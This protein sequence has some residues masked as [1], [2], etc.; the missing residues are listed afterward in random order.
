MNRT[1]T[2][3]LLAFFVA[4]SGCAGASSNDDLL[5]VSFDPPAGAS[6]DTARVQPLIGTLAEADIGPATTPGSTT[7]SNGTFTVTSSGADIW[8]PSDAFHFVYQTMVGDGEAIARVASQPNTNAWAKAGFMIRESV[9]VGAPYAFMALTPGNGALSQYRPI[10]NGGSQQTSKAGVAAPYWVRLVRAGSTFAGYTS[11]DGLA[12]TL[13]ATVTVPM[14]TN[15][16]AGLAVTSHSGGATATVTFTNV[17]VAAIGTTPIANVPPT[18]TLT[19]PAAGT[20]Y[21]APASLNLAAS[22]GDSDGTVAKVDFFQG[23]TLVGTATTGPFQAAMTGLA[24][25]T[26]FLTARATD[27]DGASTTSAPVSVTVNAAPVVTTSWKDQDIGSTG[28]AGSFV[29]AGGILTVSGAGADVWGTADAFHFAYLPLVGDGEVIARVA[30]QQNTNAWAKAGVMIRESTAAGARHAFMAMTPSYG[31]SFQR[32]ATA[33]GSS[34]STTVAGIKVP[35]WVRL[36]RAGSTFTAYTSADG[37]TWRQIGSATNAMPANAL[38]GLAVTSHKA[39]TLS[40]ATFTGMVVKSATVTPPPPAN[41]PPTVG[42]TSPASGASFTA[43]ATL[44]VSAGAADSD[45]S[46]AKVEFFQGATLIGTSTASPFQASLS[47][48]AA[49]SYALTAKATDNAGASTTSA[50]VSIA[51]AAAPVANV[52]PTVSI[53]SPANG[54]SLTAPA[55]LTVIAGA[56]DSDGAVA[57]VDFFQGSALVGTSTVTPFQVALSNLAAGT[58]ALT[59][60]ATDNAGA[61]TTSA[62]VSITVAGAPV[63]PPPGTTTTILKPEVFNATSTSLKIRWTAPAGATAVRVFLAPEPPATAGAAMPAQ[64]Q[65]ASLAG[66]AT[67]AQLT[68]LAAAVDVFLRIDVDTPSGTVSEVQHG[69]TLGGPREPLDNAVREVHG[70]GPN[71]LQIV[72]FNGNGATFQAGPWTVTRSNGAAINVTKVSRQSLPISAPSYKVGYGLDYSDSIIDADHRIYL[73]LDAPIGGPDLLTVKGPGVSFL[74]PFSDNYLETPI[75]QLNQVGY[76]PRAT[77]RYA[78]VSGWMGDGGALSLSGLSTTADVLAEPVDDSQPRTAVKS[79][80]PIT[81]RSTLDADTQAEVRQIDLGGVAAAEGVRLR[82]RIPGVGV[83][84]PT[85]ISATAAYKALFTVERGLFFNRWGADIEAVSMEFPR[86]NLDHPFVYTAESTMDFDTKFPTTQPLT[87]KRSLVG[88]YHDAGDFDQRPMHQVIPQVLMRA[89]EVNPANYLDRQFDIPEAGNGIPDLLDEAMWGVNAWVQLQE[90]A[91]GVRMGVESTRHP[92]AFY[93]ADDDPLIYWTYSRC[94]NASARA[95][96]LFAQMSR[97][98]APFDATKAA[99][100]K[101]RAISAFAWAKANAA[102]PQFLMYGASELFR[103]TALAQYDT[104]FKATWT[105]MGTYGAFNNLAESHLLFSDY[106]NPGQVMADYFLGYANAAGASADV[107]STSVTW[108]T[109]LA[110]KW[111]DAVRGNGHAHRSPRPGNYNWDWGVGTGTARFMDTV[112]ARMQLGGLTAADQQKYLNALSLSADYVLGGNP[113]GF[114]YFTRLGSRHPEEPLDL[115]SL[116]WIKEGQGASPGKPVYGPIESLPAASYMDATKAQFYPTFSAIPRG[117]R[118][119]D[120]RTIVNTN[121]YSVWEVNGPF[122]E[123]F[124]ILLGPNMT[125]PPSWLTGGAHTVDPLP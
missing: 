97:L 94:P 6:M 1:A 17:S 79:A 27:D 31:A 69:R 65:F 70:F 71:V 59:A 62:V 125:A 99:D 89:Y 5:P 3:V 38:A 110:N 41:V 40:K 75:V 39:G 103:L 51:V 64:K 60:R 56:A 114:V 101:T 28:A 91:G 61:S 124:S 54:A 123:M 9:A 55:S 72:L 122:V 95:A 96:G 10:A 98:I 34:Q 25:G 118:Y 93:H 42:I 8:G 90:S 11:A 16:L 53:T 108:L 14:G 119:A 116:A 21:T 112:I 37:I 4:A 87:G 45:G 66:S 106:K 113:N 24:A 121:E 104:E 84:W 109:T 81:V 74:L 2:L 29:N 82:V 73:T 47:G 50:V 43:P 18:V 88:G 77:E 26:W 83:S 76:N 68:G 19:S 105:S 57:R 111:A 63:T 92:W 52:A 115:D 33:G 46:I 86:P 32:R 44:T 85:Q 67:E 15:A 107:R 7:S 100:L 13:V 23:T 30:S 102:A 22:A 117:M 35:S 78:Y 12:W 58:Y 80:L 120:V 20:T 49:G 36:V 48:L